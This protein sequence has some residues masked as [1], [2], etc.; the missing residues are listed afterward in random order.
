MLRE[1]VATKS[2][3][4]DFHVEDLLSRIVDLAAESGFHLLDE[5]GNGGRSANNEEVIHIDPNV[6]RTSR[7]VQKNVDAGVQCSG[8]EAKIFECLVNHSIPDS[9]S[10]LEHIEAPDEQPH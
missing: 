9:A 7:T 4:M 3:W 2:I 10:L 6:D 1:E 5:P 8:S